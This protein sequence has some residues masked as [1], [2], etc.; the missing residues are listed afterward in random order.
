MVLPRARGFTLILGAAGRFELRWGIAGVNRHVSSADIELVG[1]VLGVPAP[2]AL[3]V[4]TN[5]RMSSFRPLA[6]YRMG[7][8]LAVPPSR[9]G[10]S[11]ECQ[12]RRFRGAV[13]QRFDTP[14]TSSGEFRLG[15]S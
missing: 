13:P 2:D 3:D 9:S 1:I 15:R 8:Q 10:R 7:P 14:D 5:I 6:S 11:F 12:C 4:R